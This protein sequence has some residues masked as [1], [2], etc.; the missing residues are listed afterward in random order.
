M[1]WQPIVVGVDASAEAAGA[2]ALGWRMAQAAGVRCR[3][4]HAC[5]DLL[6]AAT[7]PAGRPNED[8]ERAIARSARHHLETAL[9]GSVPME[10]LNALT[11]RPGRTPIVL[12][13]A[14]NEEDAG[15]V[16]LGGKHHSALNRWLGGSTALNAVRSLPV[17]VLVATG[18]ATAK[19]RIMAAVDLSHAAEPTLEAAQAMA[20]LFGGQ[21]RVLH[22]VEPIPILP[23]VPVPYDLSVMAA[24]EEARFGRE[25]WPLVTFPGAQQEVR[26]G[27][28]P[29]TI[30]AAV[31]D[32]QPD[33]LVVGSHGKGWID[34]MILGSV[35][36]S[37][38][39]GLPTSLLVVPAPVAAEAVFEPR[40]ERTAAITAQLAIA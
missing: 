19:R 33:L 23:E 22:V 24:E 15:L 10:G 31:K 26:Q 28:V 14:V 34:R 36:E 17:P 9:E 37:L 7:P 32:W 2:A 30:F 5:R 29:E 6:S 35:A 11:I 3:L 38:L 8:I 40:R 13:E 1:S 16:V 39:N 12:G 20:T 25:I 27:V 21:L 18:P 4:V